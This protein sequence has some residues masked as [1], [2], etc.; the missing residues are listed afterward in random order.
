[1]N[2]R[3]LL[4]KVSRFAYAAVGGSMLL[5]ACHSQK[6]SEYNLEEISSCDDLTGLP[7]EEIDKRNSLGYVET[8]P[9]RESTCDNCQLYLPPTAKRKC[10]GCQLFKGPVTEEGYC[11][12]WA[13]QTDLV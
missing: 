12:Y 8:T 2:R 7:Q 5:P 9:I 10:G 13:P 11:T 4:K 1:M 6:G 3:A